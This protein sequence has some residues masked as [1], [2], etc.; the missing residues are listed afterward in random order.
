MSRL[1][2]N[3]YAIDLFAGCG[4]LSE[5]F[6]Q[7]GFEITAQI[8]MDK[9]SCET[10]KTRHLYY[11][12]KKIGKEYFYPKL[13]KEEYSREDILNKFPEIR[14]S[15]SHRVIRAEFGKDSFKKIIKNIKATKKFH[16]APKIHVVTGGPPCQPYSLA[17]RARDPNRMRNDDR[18][19]LYK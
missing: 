1:K 14:E 6:K 3:F 4:G 2:N 5:G 17:G 8:D 16:K 9:W 19:F 18:H 11:E 12:L 7:A 10:L 13:L 15:I